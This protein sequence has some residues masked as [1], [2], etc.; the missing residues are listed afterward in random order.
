[1][2]LEI[3][4]FPLEY[5]SFEATNDILRHAIQMRKERGYTLKGTAI[6]L[7][8]PVRTFYNWNSGMTQYLRP[9]YFNA[10]FEYITTRD[11]PAY[12]YGTH[13]YKQH[14][15]DEKPYKV[16]FKDSDEQY[17]QAEIDQMIEEQLRGPLPPY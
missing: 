8:I 6:L 4:D 3:I 13:L 17:S 9:D 10:L 5:F 11:K 12:R 14:H 1:M 15:P 16:A 2:S 7:G